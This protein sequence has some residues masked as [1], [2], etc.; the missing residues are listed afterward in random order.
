MVLPATAIGVRNM[1][2][3]NVF[4]GLAILMSLFPFRVLAE[5][6]DSETE[7]KIGVGA[8]NSAKD[9]RAEVRAIQL[10]YSEELFL[11]LRQKTEFLGWL[12]SRGDMGRKSGGYLAKSVGV[13][14][15]PG[16]FYAQFYIG[17]GVLIPT[18]SYLGGPIQF[19]E[20]FSIGI[21]D[22]DKKSIGVAY[23]HISSAGIFVPNVGRDFIM[24]RTAIPF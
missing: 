12:D 14:V 16:Y 1:K 9:Q 22:N 24:L 8:F 10:G 7:F 2:K 20:D 13:D 19:T 17:V 6:P 18:D 23:K 3:T 5:T 4:I 15:S 21:R 11:G